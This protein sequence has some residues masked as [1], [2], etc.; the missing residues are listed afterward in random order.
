MATV[1]GIEQLRE[2]VGTGRGVG[3]DQRLRVSG[4]S[5]LDYLEPALTR[6]LR[7]LRRDGLDRGERRGV[8]GE[9]S[10]EPGDLLGRPFD[11]EQDPALVIED[12]AAELELGRETEHVGA[13]PDSLHRPRHPSANPPPARRGCRSGWGAHPRVGSASST[14]SRSTW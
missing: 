10:Q 5:G 14:S 4:A 6:G 11:L 3:R 12:V 8:L 13:K 7:V 9:A 1:G 2:A